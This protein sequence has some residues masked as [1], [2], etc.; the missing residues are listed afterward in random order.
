MAE[1]TNNWTKSTLFLLPMIEDVLGPYY[2]SYGF[3]NVYLSDHQYET[4]HEECLYV[5]YKPRFTQA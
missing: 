4:I 1:E 5:L 3:Q 2:K